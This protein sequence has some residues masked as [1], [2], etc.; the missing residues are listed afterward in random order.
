[1]ADTITQLELLL[2]Y[3]HGLGELSAYFEALRAGQAKGCRCSNCA[4]VWFPPHIACPEDGHACEWVSLDG[5]GTVLYVTETRS[6]LPFQEPEAHHIFI[7]V[8]MAGAN[9]AAFG[10]WA[11]GW[12]RPNP[13]QQVQLVAPQEEK[14][15][16]P[17]QALLFEPQEDNR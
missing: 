4:R 16:H 8:S 5:S 10:R 6:R 14:I 1:M 15:G 17:A 7:L 13:G 2:S 9:N 12:N 11:P 3:K